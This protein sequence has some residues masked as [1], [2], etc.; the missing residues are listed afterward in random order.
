MK[1]EIWHKTDDT[2][3][4]GQTL[5]FASV[6][7]ETTCELA[8]MHTSTGSLPS[9]QNTHKVVPDTGDIFVLVDEDEDIPYRAY[10]LTVG[11]CDCV[12]S[13]LPV[14]FERRG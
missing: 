5:E 3:A 2:Y 9:L 1:I 6:S 12:P 13:F 8:Y 10:E 4:K 11:N 14:T 7:D